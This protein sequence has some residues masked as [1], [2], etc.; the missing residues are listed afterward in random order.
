WFGGVGVG[1]SFAIGPRWSYCGRGD[2]FSPSLGGHLVRGAAATGIASRVHA[3]P[4]VN[5]MAS[6]GPEPSK[7][8]FAPAQVPHATGAASASLAKARQFSRASSATALGAHAPSR[9]PAASMTPMGSRP[10]LTGGGAPSGW[11]GGRSMTPSAGMPNHGMP[12]TQVPPKKKPQTEPQSAPHPSTRGRSSGG[13]H[14]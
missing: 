1:Y 6:H 13:H 10:S 14:R 2:V 4:S 8:G 7:L 5:G 3:V 12:T 9:G 11:S